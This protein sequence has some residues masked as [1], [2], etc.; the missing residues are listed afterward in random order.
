MVL[1]QLFCSD[2]ETKHFLKEN[3]AFKGHIFICKGW[4][5]CKQAVAAPN[6]SFAPTSRFLPL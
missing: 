5:E 3:D 1:N 4:Q 6:S 2:F